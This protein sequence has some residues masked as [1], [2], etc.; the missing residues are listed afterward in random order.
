[1]HRGG[2]GFDCGT[3]FGRRQQERLAAAQERAGGVGGSSRREREQSVARRQQERSFAQWEW[4]FR[5]MRFGGDCG[6]AGAVGGWRKELIE[7]RL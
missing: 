1:M 3:G 2:I 4:L 7:V 5:R 6:G